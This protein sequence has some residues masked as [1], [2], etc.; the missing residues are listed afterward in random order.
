MEETKTTSGPLVQGQL[1]LKNSSYL[2]PSVRAQACKRSGQQVCSHLAAIKQGACLGEGR[3]QLAVAA[4]C[5][6]ALAV[7]AQRCTNARRHLG[8]WRQRRQVVRAGTACRACRLVQRL[9]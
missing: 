3:V 1:R 8:W 6:A 4:G 9:R 5:H 2:E 7:A